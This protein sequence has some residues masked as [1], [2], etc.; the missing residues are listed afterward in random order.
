[1]SIPEAARHRHRY[2]FVFPSTV[3]GTVSQGAQVQARLHSNDI[4]IDRRGTGAV[5]LVSVTQRTCPVPQVMDTS[6]HRHPPSCDRRAS[7][8]LTNF[9][10][11]G[12]LASVLPI[13]FTAITEADVQRSN[14]PKFATGH[15]P[16]GT[17][18]CGNRVCVI[19][20]RSLQ[21]SVGVW[22]GLLQPMVS[23]R[24]RRIELP[25]WWPPISQT[26]YNM[27]SQ[28]SMVLR[29]R[30]RRHAGHMVGYSSLYP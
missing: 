7:P 8:M 16:K 12:T 5:P 28:S 11:R 22:M 29:A 9:D 2:G 4:A 23:E 25:R 13:S 26:N 18:H 3:N 14:D 10:P 20:T 17:P 1:M 6:A 27:V 30:M 19:A 21:R 24:E 15:S